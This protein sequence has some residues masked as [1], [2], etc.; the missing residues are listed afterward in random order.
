MAAVVGIDEAELTMGFNGD[1]L[2]VVVTSCPQEAFCLIILNFSSYNMFSHV[3]YE[4][5]CLRSVGFGNY[6]RFKR[7]YEGKIKSVLHSVTS[8][9][10]KYEEG[11]FTKV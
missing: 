10:L 7:K 9:T 1:M 11:I 4:K 6:G 3:T 5:S 8:R 2:K